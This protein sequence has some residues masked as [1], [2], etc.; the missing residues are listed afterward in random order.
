MRAR[1]PEV[2]FFLRTVPPKVRLVIAVLGEYQNIAK[3]FDF[4]IF[5]AVFQ[6]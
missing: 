6:S 1:N 5:T 4:I 3:V 2:R